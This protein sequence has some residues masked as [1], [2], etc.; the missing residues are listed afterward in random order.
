[1]AE[2]LKPEDAAPPEMTDT[3]F[4]EAVQSINFTK[5]EA[6]EHQ[7]EAAKLT[8]DF[9]DRHNLD[10]AAFTKV[11]Q[12]AK[13][14]DQHKALGFIREFIIGCRRIGFFA[15]VDAFSDA[16]LLSV[17]RQI[18]AEADSGGDMTRNGAEREEEALAAE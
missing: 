7:G 18:I 15:Q 16:D 12:L 4:R 14:E 5:R 1:M 17:L 3:E 10:K 6:S 9:C 8:K 11:C 2:Q 13:M